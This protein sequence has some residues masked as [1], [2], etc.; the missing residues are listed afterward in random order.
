MSSGVVADVNGWVENKV[1]EFRV[2]CENENG[3]RCPKEVERWKYI[4]QKQECT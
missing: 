3:L 2:P 1:K 4:F